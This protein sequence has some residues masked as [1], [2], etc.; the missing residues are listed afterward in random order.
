M[1]EIDVACPMC[2]DINR[3][4]SGLSAV[5]C[6]SCGAAFAVPMQKADIY[7]PEE[8]PVKNAPVFEIRAGVLEKYN[9]S[10]PV[11]YVPE[12]VKHEFG[13]DWGRFR[14]EAFAEAMKSGR[15]L[16]RQNAK[17]AM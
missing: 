5:V 10:D 3:V 8:Q 16:K 6:Q 9:G 2:G 4:E 11:V 15:Q 14:W 17:K 1:T 7:S 12:S 13:D